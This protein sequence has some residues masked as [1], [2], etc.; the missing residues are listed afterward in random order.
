MP[1]SKKN[2]NKLLFLIFFVVSF[3]LVYQITYNAGKSNSI[4]FYEILNLLYL[5]KAI[6]NLLYYIY[7]LKI[8]TICFLIA[9][10]FIFMIRF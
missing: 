9:S 2:R 7:I 6:M 8:E 1:I 3:A 4:Y 5:P 10:L